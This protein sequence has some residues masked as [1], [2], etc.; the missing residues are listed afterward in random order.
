MMQSICYPTISHYVS[1]SIGTILVHTMA[2]LDRLGR[3]MADPLAPSRGRRASH[4]ERQHNTAVLVI[5]TSASMSDADWPPS[6]LRAAQDAARKFTRRLHRDSPDTR[7]GII[8]FSG[9]AR[10]VAKLTPAADLARLTRSIDSAAVESST[11]ITA[12]LRKAE[13][14]LKRVGGPCHIIL[15]TDGVHYARPQPHKAASRLRS[16]GTLE[17]VGI[18]GSPADVDEEL[19]KEIASARPDGSKRYRWIG[20]GEELVKHFE[21]LAEGL[22]RR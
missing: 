3:F 8:T 12:G 7:V 19:L 2:M 14:L 20:D 9:T 18:G 11:N 6:R 1:G 5:D 4:E 21:C 13:S 15:L 17:T 10:V 22:V 16:V